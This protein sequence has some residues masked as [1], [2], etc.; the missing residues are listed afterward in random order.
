M[1]GAYSSKY[2]KL[3]LNCV[4]LFPVSW[5]LIF[6]LDGYAALNFK[7]RCHLYFPSRLI[8]LTNGHALQHWLVRRIAWPNQVKCE[9]CIANGFPKLTCKM[10]LNVLASARLGSISSNLVSVKN[11]PKYNALYELFLIYCPMVRFQLKNVLA[12]SISQVGYSFL[13]HHQSN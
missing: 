13:P 12:H 4:R 7:L 9:E 1:C 3:L 5:L 6:E 2:G 10:K 11:Y 8:I